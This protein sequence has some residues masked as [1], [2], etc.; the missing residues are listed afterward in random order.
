MNHSASSDLSEESAE[1][2]MVLVGRT[3]KCSAR[4]VILA[5]HSANSPH[6]PSEFPMDA[7][8]SALFHVERKQAKNFVSNSTVLRMRSLLPPVPSRKKPV[9][10]PCSGVTAT[11]NAAEKAPELSGLLIRGLLTSLVMP[12]QSVLP[13]VPKIS[14]HRKIYETLECLRNR[15]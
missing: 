9:L 2:C 5:T 12:P 1:F 6:I 15:L 13:F 14:L 7:L 4:R 11:E 10:A 3:Q 8:I